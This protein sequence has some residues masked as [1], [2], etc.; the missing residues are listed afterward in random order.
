MNIMNI[1]LCEF[2]ILSIMLFFFNPQ[3]QLEKSPNPS[4]DT[5]TELS[6]LFEEEF[7]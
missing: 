5:L 7:K 6:K 4:I 1:Y 2:C 3:E